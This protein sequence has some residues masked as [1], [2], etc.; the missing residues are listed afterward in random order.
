M[1][2]HLPRQPD[3][4]LQAGWSGDRVGGWG[5]HAEPLGGDAP[6][7]SP[8]RRPGAHRGAGRARAAEPAAAIRKGE[9]AAGAA[10]GLVGA[11]ATHDVRRDRASRRPRRG[12]VPKRARGRG[13]GASGGRAAGCTAEGVAGL[14]CPM[15]FARHGTGSLASDAFRKKGSLGA[16]CRLSGWAALPAPRCRQAAPGPWGRARFR[17]CPATAFLPLWA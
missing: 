7:A 1:R 6:A 10:H 13:S 12:A 15:T 4:P 11:S 17:V 9:A 14:R 3:D 5:G 8:A 2:R 16:S